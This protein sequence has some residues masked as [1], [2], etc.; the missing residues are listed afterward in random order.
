MAGKIFSLPSC[1][2]L[3]SAW[4]F[5]V[6]IITNFAWPIIQYIDVCVLFFD[7]IIFKKYP[8]YSQFGFFP[9]NIPVDQEGLCSRFSFILKY[10]LWIMLGPLICRKRA[11]KGFSVPSPVWFYYEVSWTCEHWLLKKVLATEL[12]LY[13]LILLKQN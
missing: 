5:L 8:S 9:L 11:F 1:R 2:K 3:K 7:S 6:I 12:Y 10:T 4:L 13:F